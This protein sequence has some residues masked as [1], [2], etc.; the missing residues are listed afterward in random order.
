[1]PGCTL[2]V[3]CEPPVFTYPHALT[4]QNLAANGTIVPISGDAAIGGCVLALSGLSV[5]F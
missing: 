3:G 5:L 1:M 4:A 2:P